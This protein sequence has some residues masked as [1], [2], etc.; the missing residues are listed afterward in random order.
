MK[1]YIITCNGHIS[2]AAFSDFDDAEKW[3]LSRE[4]R[5][6]KYERG[7][8]YLAGRNTYKIHEVFINE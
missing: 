8:I 1:A 3:V 4:D 6:M 7:W 2:S 5:P